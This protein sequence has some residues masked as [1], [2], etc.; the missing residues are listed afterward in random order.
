MSTRLLSSLE[1]QVH[2]LQLKNKRL[3][4]QTR[5][6]SAVMGAVVAD[7]AC[8]PL[9]WNYDI[10][11]LKD[12]LE[13]ANRLGTPEFFIGPESISANPFYSVK[14][15]KFTCYGDQAMVLLT[16]LA[17]NGGLDINDLKQRTYDFFGPDG[18]DSYGEWPQISVPKDQLPVKHGWRHGSIKGFLANAEDG[19]PFPEC[20]NTNDSQIDCIA[21]IAPVV[22][23]YAG[24][25][26]MAQKVEE[27]V[28]LTQNND[29]S[30]EH[31][32]TAAKILEAVILGKTTRE[33]IRDVVEGM[34]GDGDSEQSKL[35]S[36][37]LDILQQASAEATMH[38]SHADVVAKIGKS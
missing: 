3:K 24:Q 29:K 4:A 17:S 22:A 38:T 33:A 15:G 5:A 11:A 37:M 9:H 13:V 12:K 2:A 26:D 21:K 19:K 10:A 36:A 28:R 25:P 32:L 8:Q 14:L 23:R 20:G 30:V 31:A 35:K 6:V 27:V 7:V 16:S 18:T 1:S 34:S